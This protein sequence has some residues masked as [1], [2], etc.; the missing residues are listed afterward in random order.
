MDAG[1]SAIGRG[2]D[3]R[4]GAGG[5][6]R[7]RRAPGLRGRPDSDES[8]GQRAAGAE[9]QEVRGALG[10]RRA[11]RDR[12]G[13]PAVVEPPVTQLHRRGREDGSEAFARSASR[14]SA[15]SPISGRKSVDAPVTASVASGWYSTALASTYSKS[16]GHRVWYT[17]SISARTSTTG[18]ARSSA[19]QRISSLAN[20]G[21]AQPRRPSGRELSSHA[22]VITPADAP[23]TASK[24]GT[25]PSSCS[26][27]AMP[28]ETAAHPAALDRQRHAQ[29]VGSTSRCAARAQPLAEYPKDVSRLFISRCAHRV[30]G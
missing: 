17:T 14:S 11:E 1:A 9:H 5:A 20:D 7:A 3:S 29:P 10:E 23:Y 28:A 6:D 25:R 27:S 21:S 19:R 2:A 12:L 24:A 30:P 16:I 22:P 8:G 4:D 15:G 13:D 26:A 18:W